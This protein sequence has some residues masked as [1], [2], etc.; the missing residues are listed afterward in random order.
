MHSRQL[1]FHGIG[2]H[3]EDLA[4]K[5]GGSLSGPQTFAKI[6]AHG[7]AGGAMNMLQGGKFGHGFCLSWCHA[8]SSSWNQQCSRS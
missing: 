4:N 2:D 1:F 3:F 6:L 8:G 5:G 7:M